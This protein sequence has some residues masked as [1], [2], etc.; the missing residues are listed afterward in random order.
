MYI[1]IYI[2]IHKGFLHIINVC[3]FHKGSTQAKEAVH[4]PFGPGAIVRGHDQ[5][6]V[7]IVVHLGM[8]LG[9]H[10]NDNVFYH[11]DQLLNNEQFLKPLGS[12]DCDHISS[13]S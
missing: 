2:Y 10:V 6:F 13:S 12:T 11:G 4:L 7:A 3:R 9:S 5:L 8:P 1:Y